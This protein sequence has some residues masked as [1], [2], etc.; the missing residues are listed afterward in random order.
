MPSPLPTRE[1][2]PIDSGKDSKDSE[3]TVEGLGVLGLGVAGFRGL[4][5]RVQGFRGLVFGGLGV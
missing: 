4:G 2:A 5:F 3:Y 1:Q